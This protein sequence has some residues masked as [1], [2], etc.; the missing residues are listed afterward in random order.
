MVPPE[1]NGFPFDPNFEGWKPIS[2][3]DRGDKNTFRFVLGNNVAVKAALSGNISPWP[4]GTCFA[5]VAWLQESG[6]DGPLHPV[7]C[8]LRRYREAR[9]ARPKLSHRRC[10]LPNRRCTA[11]VT[12]QTTQESV[13]WRAGP[14]I[15]TGDVPFNADGSKGDSFKTRRGT[16]PPSRLRDSPTSILLQRI[17]RAVRLAIAAES[18]LRGESSWRALFQSDR[19]RPS[20]Q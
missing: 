20:G 7:V 18:R 5:K 6:P 19:A 10:V 13:C 12:K 1:F 17:P 16:V 15:E 8:S 14:I 2:T 3:T 4:D 11:S 9:S